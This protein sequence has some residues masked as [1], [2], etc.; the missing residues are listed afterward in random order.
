MMAAAGLSMAYHPKP[1]VRER[2][3]ISILSGGMD[4]VLEV[5]RA[6]CRCTA[7]IRCQHADDSRACVSFSAYCGGLIT[8]STVWS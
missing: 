8:S 5:V 7:A 4:R 3:M 1:A 6:W 2:A